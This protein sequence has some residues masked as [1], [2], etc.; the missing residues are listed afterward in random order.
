ML[1]QKLS[2]FQLLLSRHLTFH[3]VVA[4]HLRCGEIFSDSY[5]Y[6]FSPDF[7]GEIIRKIG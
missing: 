3:K 4:T 5:Y 6:K 1:L 7:D 2:R